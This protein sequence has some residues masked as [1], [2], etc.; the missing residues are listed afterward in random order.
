MNCLLDLFEDSFGIWLAEVPL[1]QNTEDP[2][3]IVDPPGHPVVRNE[4]SE[5]LLSEPLN[6]R[7][8]V[9]DQFPRSREFGDFGN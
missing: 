5:I 2:F 6:G 9:P 4:E 3:V 1:C 7:A 8:E